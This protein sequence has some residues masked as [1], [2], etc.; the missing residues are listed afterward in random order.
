MFD[1]VFPDTVLQYAVVRLFGERT[2]S[3]YVTVGVGEARR[4]LGQIMV[5]ASAG[6]VMNEGIVSATTCSYSMSS[7]VRDHSICSTVFVNDTVYVAQ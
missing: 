6:V 1:Y 5:R 7:L 3:E 4:Q 2:G